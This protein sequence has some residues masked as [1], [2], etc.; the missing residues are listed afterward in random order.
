MLAASVLVFSVLATAWLLLAARGQTPG[1]YLSS[2]CRHGRRRRRRRRR[3]RRRRHAR[4]RLATTLPW[5][6]INAAALP[7][8]LMRMVVA[9]DA[10]PFA[11]MVLGTATASAADVKFKPKLNAVPGSGEK[12]ASSNLNAVAAEVRAPRQ[13]RDLLGVVVFFACQYLI[14]TM[15]DNYL[16]QSSSSSKSWSEWMFGSS[17]WSPFDLWFD[18]WKHVGKTIRRAGGRWPLPP[19]YLRV[20]HGLLS[21]DS[22]DVGAPLLHG[23]P[24]GVHGRVHL[25]V[26]CHGG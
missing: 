5:A 9:P 17:R 6:A 10:K 14:I 8:E 11:D 18:F 21:P 15:V 20:H 4:P 7:V 2:L 16:E 22:S 13:W 12:V 19:R 26:E 3:K 25:P 23:H 24:H 1:M